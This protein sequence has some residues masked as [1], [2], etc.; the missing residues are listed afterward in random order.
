MTLEEIELLV[1][2][3]QGVALIFAI[4][5]GGGWTLFTFIRLQSVS[6]AKAELVEAQRNAEL[7]SVLQ[8][9]IEAY[10]VPSRDDR[11]FYITVDV[12]AEN[13]GNKD[14]YID[15]AQSTCIVNKVE[16]DANGVAQLK[17]VARTTF[18]FLTYIVLAGKVV[19]L[20]FLFR[21]DDY[22]IYRVDF[23]SR[24]PE[25]ESKRAEQIVPD[26][27]E[28]VTDRTWVTSK[29][30]SV[31]SEFH[32]DETLV[33]LG[34]K[35]RSGSKISIDSGADDSDVNSFEHSAPESEIETIKRKSTNGVSMGGCIVEGQVVKMQNGVS[36]VQELRIG[37]LVWSFS[38]KY[39]SY[40]VG[41]IELNEMH[42]VP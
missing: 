18:D 12:K 24:I 35:V 19:H 38:P 13:L 10:Q 26:V 21:L 20:P 39:R 34:P 23:K 31:K 11:S 22:G 9:D 14:T 16:F 6:I 36:V 25:S 37:D 3:I 7:R 28:S 32:N 8:W 30:I 15:A 1:N 4:I 29:F 5:V 2:I 41:K 27:I 40:K 33:E 17:E 42:L